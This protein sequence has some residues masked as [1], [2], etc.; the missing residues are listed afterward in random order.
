MFKLDKRQVTVSFL[1]CILIPLLLPSKYL[2]DGMGRYNYGAPFSY[3]TIYQNHP[4]S[5]WLGENFFTGNEGVLINPLPFLLN[6]MII[7]LLIRF[8]STKINSKQKLSL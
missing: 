5:K 3:I 8:F 7:Y 6:L 2:E 4:T 1:F